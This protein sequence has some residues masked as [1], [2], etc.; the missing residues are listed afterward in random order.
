MAQKNNCIQLFTELLQKGD[1]NSGQVSVHINIEDVVVAR[2]S[3]YIQDCILHWDNTLEIDNETIEIMINLNEE[4]MIFDELE[5]SFIIHDNGYD[6]VID[7][8]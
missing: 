1:G 2:A 8:I 5:N 6:I 4:N 3:V 7:F